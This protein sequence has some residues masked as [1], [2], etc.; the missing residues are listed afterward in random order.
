MRTCPLA[1]AVASF[2]LCAATVSYADEGGPIFTF[3]AATSYTFD[4]NQPDNQVTDENRKLYANG[5]S[6]E[7]FNIDLV[8]LGISGTRG[9]V[10]Y[11]AK[12]DFGDWTRSIQDN[13]NGDFA[14]QEMFFTVDTP[15]GLVTAGRMPTPFGY[16]VLEP[17]ADANISRSR[18][19]YFQSISH[20]GVALSGRLGSASLMAAI[21][22]GFHL[23]N[24]G[25]DNPDDEYGVLASAGIP[26][27]EATA[28]LSAVYSDEKDSV[29]YVEVNGVLAGSHERYRYG[30]EGTYLNGDGH[31]NG[32]PTDPVPQDSW[33]WDLTSYGGATFFEKWSTDF[34]L[35]YTDQKGTNGNYF[36][37]NRDKIVSFTATGGYEIVD[38][39]VFRVEYRIDSSDNP[40]F[41]DNNSSLSLVG[42]VGQS[43][44]VNVV[45]CQLMW[46]PAT[47]SD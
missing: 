43:D 45:Q 12:L 40:I 18:A 6:E 46:T 21:I 1:A 16:E 35:S 20:D 23:N 25:A 11:G 7:S 10:S 3:G 8:Q 38:G 36:T 26:I 28:R 30:L 42:P 4:I 5:W 37:R 22:N 39:V 33:M 19:W 9:P 44:L 27:G 32:T 41:D 17:W 29:R 14:L 2:L 31:G 34:R 13:V 47:G 15:V 24:I